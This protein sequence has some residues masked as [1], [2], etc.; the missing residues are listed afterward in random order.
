[1]A[2]GKYNGV[3]LEL[4]FFLLHHS[5]SL[6]PAGQFFITLTSALR[7]A[8]KDVT[9]AC[10]VIV[11][12]EVLNLNIAAALPV[13]ILKEEFTTYNLIEHMCGRECH[14]F[15]EHTHITEPYFQQILL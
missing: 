3:G 13:I 14:R 12:V 6:S 8:C 1:M 2:G 10:V 5:L 9:A 4:P 7:A 11:V 15:C